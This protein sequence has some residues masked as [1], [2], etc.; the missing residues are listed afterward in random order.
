ML[1]YSHQIA[2]C[3]NIKKLSGLGCCQYQKLAPPPPP[4]LLEIAKI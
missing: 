1:S 2:H 4:S 3:G